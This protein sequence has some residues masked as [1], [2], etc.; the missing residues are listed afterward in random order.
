M[1]IKP[2]K[3]ILKALRDEHWS[4]QINREP[5]EMKFPNAMINKRRF[6]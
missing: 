2:F 1:I 6:N 3:N 4:L 5:V